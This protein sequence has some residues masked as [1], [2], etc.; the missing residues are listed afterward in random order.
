MGYVGRNSET[1]SSPGQFGGK[2]RRRFL[3][4]CVGSSATVDCFVR[5]V[6][7][8]LQGKHAFGRGCVA[9]TDAKQDV[10]AGVRDLQVKSALL[11]HVRSAEVRFVG[12]A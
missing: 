1:E 6:V 4:C 7:C 3:L 9:S 2:A 10:L 8:C 5:L 11:P 12:A